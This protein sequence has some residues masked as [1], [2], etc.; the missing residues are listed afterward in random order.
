MKK[1]LQRA[2]ICICVLFFVSAAA[3]VG[4]MLNYEKL[5]PEVTTVQE[6]TTEAATTTVPETTKAEPTA[7][8]TTQKPVIDFEDISVIDVY[9]LS[10][11]SGSWDVKHCQ[12]IAIDKKNQF[13]YYSYTHTFVKCD[14]AGNVLG[15]I[16]GIKGH[17][18]D[19]CF[20]EEDGRVYASLNAPSKRALYIAIIDVD[21]LDEIGL[22]AVKCGLIRT[23]H[24]HEVWN[25]RHTT[26]SLESG[27]VQQRYGVGGTDGVCFGPSFMTGE[28]NYLTVGCGTKIQPE[29]PDNDYQVILQYDVT[30]WWNV[31]AQPLSYKQYHH[32]GPYTHD[33]KYFVYTGHTTSGIQTMV[34]FDELNMW[35]LSVYP[36]RKKQ[37]NPYTLFVIDGD[38]KPYKAELI[39]QPE[40]DEQ[41]VLTLYSDGDYDKKHGI[42][43]WYS[44]NG[45]KGIE[46]MGDGLFY[47]IHPFK[48]W[49]KTQT[50]VAY[51]YVWD[52]SQESPFTL[53][54]AVPNDYTISK[55][56]TKTV[57]SEQ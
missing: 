31:Y 39:G 3:F 15:T 57:R 12:G 1:I 21:N 38:V 5:F 50:A 48:T 2:A 42:Y 52:P 53:A 55:N 6:T 36:T 26:V 54:A 13:I 14:F 8:Q 35:L 18:G 51:L 19:I 25:D 9:P 33:G 46:Y 20:N 37:F 22:K 47:V 28:G 45:N 11:A 16:T 17:L 7:V 23:V 32:T 4:I 34:Y 41:Y 30:A 56:A 49:Y 27:D 43:G 29:R 10:L 44:T 40:K 24:L